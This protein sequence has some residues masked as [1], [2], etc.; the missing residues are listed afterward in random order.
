MKIRRVVIENYRSV[1]R[2]ELDGL[3]D[4]VVFYGPNGGGKTNLLRGIS[5]AFAVLAR[6]AREGLPAW[7]D[8]PPWL[9]ALFTLRDLRIGTHRAILGV[10]LDVR[11]EPLARIDEQ[12][13]LEE[14]SFRCAVEHVGGG[15]L[16][17]STPSVVATG[18]HASFHWDLVALLGTTSQR[19]RPAQSDAEPADD[20]A[21]RPSAVRR[22]LIDGVGRRGFYRC[23]DV[24]SF[25]PC[26]RDAAQDG[27]HQTIQDFLLAGRVEEAISR[28][29]VSGDDAQ[30]ERFELLRAIL[31]RKPLELPD[32]E[33]VVPNKR[34]ELRFRTRT[35]GKTTVPSNAT[36]LGMQQIVIL[37][38][39][40]LFCEARSCAVEEPEAHLHAP[41]SGRALRQVLRELVRD[42][43]IDQLF[44]AT[45]SNLYDLD[46][47]GFWSIALEGDHTVARYETQLSRIDQDHLFEPGA[48]KRVL[49]DLLRHGDAAEIVAYGADGA[50]ITA[51]AMLDELQSDSET[52]VRYAAEL[53]R[54][55]ARMFL[56]RPPHLGGV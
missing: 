46:P 35:P 26:E 53:S 39:V 45:H 56:R 40:L 37:L 8:N 29:A 6:M 42:G 7:L 44:V 30:R 31:V 21:R 38:G 36:S 23:D 10:A 20:L 4:F 41:T 28:A 5:T 49:Q 47:Q 24:R 33:A 54:A 16:R 55:A 32:I 1:G 52:G 3:G 25:Q 17:V 13:E 22:L 27:T 12:H 43:M 48:A 14:V 9:Q 2:V 34:Y 19:E 50:P 51:A 15:V 11:D 18:T